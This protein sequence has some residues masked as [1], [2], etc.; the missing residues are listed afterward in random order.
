MADR[1]IQHKRLFL[2]AMVSHNAS[3]VRDRESSKEAEGGGGGLVDPIASGPGPF[4]M[5]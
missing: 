4:V 3:E 1:I 2:G 5:I